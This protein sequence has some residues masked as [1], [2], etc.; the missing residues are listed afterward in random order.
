MCAP[1]AVQCRS[2]RRRGQVRNLPSIDELGAPLPRL[3]IL[4]QPPAVRQNSWGDTEL[5]TAND[6]S[7]DGSSGF[8]VTYNSDLAILLCVREKLETMRKYIMDGIRG[9][10]VAGGVSSNVPLFWLK[11]TNGG[12]LIAKGEVFL[13][14]IDDLTF[15]A[16]CIF[17][18]ACRLQWDSDVVAIN[19]IREIPVQLASP[20]FT[21][22]HLTQVYN[23]F[24]GR[25]GAPGRDFVWN[26][27]VARSETDLVQVQ[28]SVSDLEYPRGFEPNTKFVRA[29][30]TF[31]GYWVL[32]GHGGCVIHFIN[33]TD[34]K[35]RL[36]PDWL[37][38]S[39]IKKSPA[40]LDQLKTFILKQFESR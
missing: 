14:G 40:K 29:E 37:V 3:Q 30:T 1:G 34:I 4:S 12:P 28:Y 6:D 25:F 22:E 21:Y 9:G 15:V 16:K 5:Y 32:K 36:L 33:Q 35:G 26:S 11:P 18:P 13:E 8:P 31:S 2:S 38:D 20:D 19:V 23:S 7:C 27:Y 39:V 10:F 24:K 17:D